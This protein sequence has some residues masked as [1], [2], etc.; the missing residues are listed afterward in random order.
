MNI[1]VRSEGASGREVRITGEIQGIE[2]SILFKRTLTEV[3]EKNPGETV[4]VYMEDAHT[5]PSSVIG[6]LL[7]FI[8]KDHVRMTLFIKKQELFSL[9]NTMKLT[10][11]LNA[12]KV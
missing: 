8:H 11:I 4:S 3:L 2:E 7:K 9:M 10:D 1:T 5:L 12:R 6:S